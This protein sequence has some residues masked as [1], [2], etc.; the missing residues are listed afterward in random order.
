MAPDR[1]TLTEAATKPTEGA[2][3][4]GG[5]PETANSASLQF[6]RLVAARRLELG[7]SRGELAARMGA[8]HSVVERIEAGEPLSI[9]G[10]QRLTDALRMETEPSALRRL[11]DRAAPGS[12]GSRIPDEA[13]GRQRLSDGLAGTSKALKQLA[14][15]LDLERPKAALKRVS[16]QATE[17]IQRA[18]A[19]DRAQ[20]S[21][22]AGLGVAAVAAV[23]LSL[24]AAGANW[25]VIGLTAV[26]VA[27]LW[28]SVILVQPGADTRAPARTIV[29]LWLLVIAVGLVFSGGPGAIDPRGD[30]SVNAAPVAVTLAQN[31]AAGAIL[32]SDAAS[33]SQET[34]TKAKSQKDPP[35]P[36]PS[37]EPKP[38]SNE[39]ASP[40]VAASTPTAAPPSS[41]S[42]G[43]SPH[44]KPGGLSSQNGSSGGNN[45]SSGGGSQSGSGS[46]SSGSS[47]NL[48]NTVGSL[49]NAI[50]RP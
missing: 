8:T 7:L 32:G 6:G 3:N 18:R 11:I 47:G 44:V 34:A 28:L 16:D 14:A 22:R 1:D 13:R 41:S 39:P 19:F 29:G 15:A 48:G 38:S 20:I 9:E 21:T 30:A 24:V 4:G 45:S 26:T 2:A 17:Q 31:G 42:S 23:L 10:R 40:S 5:V 36:P 27:A 33:A 25:A 49:G 50:T 43:S 12:D 35:T 46:G 37:N